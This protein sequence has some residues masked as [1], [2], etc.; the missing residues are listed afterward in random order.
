M[1][2]KDGLVN[3]DTTVKTKSIL[4]I[5]ANNIFTL[6]NFLNL[7]LGLAIFLVGSY[8]NL[9]FLGV[10]I[11]NTLIS[12]IQ[13]IRSKMIIDK[14]SII[15]ATKVKVIRNGL[16]QM[17]KIDEIVLDDI[18]EASS[19]EQVVTDAIIV[20]GSCEVNEAL[21]TVNQILFIRKKE[22]CFYL[23]VLL[24]VVSV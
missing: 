16:E 13:E 14:L 4:E 2:K 17:I 23:V 18:I 24:L 22:I 10:V 5:M 21:I 11:C 7:G 12:I 20:D 9:I 19:G 1:R 6:F 8:K 15:S 3:I